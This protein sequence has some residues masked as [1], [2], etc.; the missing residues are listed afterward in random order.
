MKEREDERHLALVRIS[1][2][3]IENVQRAEDFAALL[4]RDVDDAAE[5]RALNLQRSANSAQ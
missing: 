2:L 4:D 1:A 5:P 3:A